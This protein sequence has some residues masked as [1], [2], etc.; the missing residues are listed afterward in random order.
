M[1]E[2]QIL[3][4]AK[5]YLEQMTQGIDPLT[6]TLIPPTDLTQNDRIKRCLTYVSGVLGQVIDQGGIHPPQSEQLPPFAITEQQLSQYPYSDRPLGIS[7]I[8][9]RINELVPPNRT[10]RLTYAPI[11]QWLT[12]QGYLVEEGVDDKHKRRV[13]TEQGRGI[14]ITIAQREGPNGDY[15]AVL[16]DREAQAFLVSHL[17]V[18][19]A[20]GGSGK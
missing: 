3:Q 6:G 8:V 17:P 7:Q 10:K 4:H 2:L 14:G 18:I 9:G 12:L 13:P 15:L 11:V 20:S 16:Y 5:S 19:L 1:T